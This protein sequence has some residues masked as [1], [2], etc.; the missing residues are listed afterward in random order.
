MQLVLDRQPLCCSSF[1]PLLLL[2]TDT[3]SLAH[4][5]THTH[6][7]SLSLSLTHSLTHTLSLPPISVLLHSVHLCADTPSEANTERLLQLVGQCVTH[8][9]VSDHNNDDDD[10][11]DDDD[12]N[13][14]D[15]DEDDD[16]DEEELNQTMRHPTL[17]MPVRFF[18]SPVCLCEC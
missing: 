1:K 8:G 7:H 5:H 15:E 10:D 2:N 17:G 4:T 6:T 11:D 12:E 13:D 16:D 9:I 14:E 3:I 18:Q